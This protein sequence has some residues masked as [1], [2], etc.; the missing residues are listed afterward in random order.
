[1]CLDPKARLGAGKLGSE[2]DYEGLKAHPFFEGVDFNNL[3]H[4][5]PPKHDIASPFENLGDLDMEWQME[6]KSRQYQNEEAKE[7]VLEI[8]NE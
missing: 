5:E 8:N 6:N 1:L 2:R 4:Q 7:Q 3:H